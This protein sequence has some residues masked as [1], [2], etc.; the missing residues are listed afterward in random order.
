GDN[1]VIECVPIGAALRTT[2]A[3]HPQTLSSWLL[4]SPGACQLAIS[5]LTA[6]FAMAFRVRRIAD[7]R[8]T[9]RA[10]S[11]CE[12]LFASPD[13]PCERSGFLVGYR[14]SRQFEGQLDLAVMIAL[15]EDQELDQKNRMSEVK[16]HV[17]TCFDSVLYRVANSSGAFVQ[18]L[19]NAF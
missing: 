10:A 14:A 16:V 18:H 1:R 7:L 3:N 2:G 12:G 9:S 4:I 15:V 6:K 13:A 17:A 8:R 5:L 11:L 19:R